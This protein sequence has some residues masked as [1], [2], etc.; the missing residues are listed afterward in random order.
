MMAWLDSRKIIDM[1]WQKVREMMEN[2]R[3]L[4]ISAKKG[5]E[6]D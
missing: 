6:D 2:A 3:K 5:G 1:E 4:D